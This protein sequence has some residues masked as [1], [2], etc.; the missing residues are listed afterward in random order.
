MPPREAHTA[1]E[2]LAVF[3]MRVRAAA[4]GDWLQELDHNQAVEHSLRFEY[5]RLARFGIVGAH[6]KCVE[7]RDQRD[8]RVGRP[9]FRNVISPGDLPSAVFKSMFGPV[10]HHFA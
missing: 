1:G 9:E 3:C 10:V 2:K 8:Q 6:P 7:T 5:S 4:P